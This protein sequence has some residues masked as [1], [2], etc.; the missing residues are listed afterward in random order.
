MPWGNFFKQKKKTAGLGLTGAA[1]LAATLLIKPWEGRVYTPYKDVGNVITVCD[2]HTGPDIIWG[3]TYTDAEC[4]QFLADDTKIAEAGVDKYLLTDPPEAV[5]A[6]FISFTF[7]VGVNAFRTSTL[8]KMANRNDFLGA[9]NQLSRWVHVNGVVYKGLVNRRV[10]G[11][12][13]R[14]SERQLCLRGLE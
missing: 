13:T 2:G 14:I 3:K 5:K 1:L 6:A 11:D 4:D 8:L 12:D 7:N 10:L 9:C